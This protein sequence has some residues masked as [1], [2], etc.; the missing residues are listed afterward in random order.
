MTWTV[1]LL[2]NDRGHLTVQ[3]GVDLV[4][5]CWVVFADD[6]AQG[7]SVEEVNDAWLVREAGVDAA[8][9]SVL[10]EPL[11]ECSIGFMQIPFQ[12]YSRS[13]AAV[14]L[15]RKPSEAP[16]SRKKPPVLPA[17]ISTT[18]RSCPYCEYIGLLT[19]G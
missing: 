8:A 3:R 15:H 1:Y 2:L 14:L 11:E 16:E 12:P 6:S 5:E 10:D 19:I 18:R 17:R 13:S 9:A 7:A 4:Q